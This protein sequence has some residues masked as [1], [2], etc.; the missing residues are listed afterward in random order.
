MYNVHHM[1]AVHT[2]A[3]ENMGSPGMGVTDVVSLSQ[4][5]AK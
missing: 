1:H 4:Y 5:T 3:K 2:E